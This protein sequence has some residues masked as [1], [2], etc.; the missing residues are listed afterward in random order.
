MPVKTLQHITLSDPTQ[1]MGPVQLPC[2]ARVFMLY[3]LHLPSLNINCDV[4]QFLHVL[5]NTTT[6]LDVF[7]VLCS[8]TTPLY[9]SHARPQRSLRL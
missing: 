6:P 8:T 7:V 5:C 4:P 9:V 1:G 2:Q 3:I